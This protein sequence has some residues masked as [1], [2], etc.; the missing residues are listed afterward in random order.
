MATRRLT[1]RDPIQFGKLIVDIATGQVDDRLEDTRDPQAI[2]RGKL[3]GEKG[4]PARFLSRG[5][6]PAGH[7]TNP[8]A[9]Y[10]T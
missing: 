10:Q 1:S 8:P 7:P 6:D 4:G 9:S 5:F 3:G 2:E